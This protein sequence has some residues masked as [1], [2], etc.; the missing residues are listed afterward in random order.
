M[1]FL[2]CHLTNR[3]SMLR[4]L[5]FLS[6]PD[7]HSELYKKTANLIGTQRIS[8]ETPTETNFFFFHQ[9]LIVHIAVVVERF[10]TLYGLEN[11]FWTSTYK[12]VWV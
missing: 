3:Q 5:H 8:C 11:F 12:S 4:K 2:K 9:S 10:L 7:L 6:N 1:K